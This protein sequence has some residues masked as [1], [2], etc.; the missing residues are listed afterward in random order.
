MSQLSHDI[1]AICESAGVVLY[2]IETTQEHDESIYRV[3]IIAKSGVSLEKCAEVSR[4]IS[5]LLD[6]TPPMGGE[7]RLEVS[8]PGVERK[9]TRPVH[10][11]YSIGERISVKYA[12]N[13]RIEGELIEATDT[14]FTLKTDVEEIRISYLDVKSART[15]FQW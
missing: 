8:S 14:E 12:A 13:E 15:V 7:Y 1:G 3:T 2:D 6:V 9:L 4:L 10:Y 5:P 11:Q